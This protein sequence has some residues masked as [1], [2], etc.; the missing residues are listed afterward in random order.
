MFSTWRLSAILFE[1]NPVVLHLLVF[2]NMLK[3]FCLANA[4]NLPDLAT[5]DPICTLT[6]GAV[7]VVHE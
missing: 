2:F 7:C 1:D 6:L 5:V 3:K 4:C